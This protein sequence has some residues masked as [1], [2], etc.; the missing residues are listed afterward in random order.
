MNRVTAYAKLHGKP[1]SAE[2]AA[3]ALEDLVTPGPTTREPPVILNAVVRH[4]GVSV[5]DLQGK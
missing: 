2:V 3:E 4:F 1:V 5:D